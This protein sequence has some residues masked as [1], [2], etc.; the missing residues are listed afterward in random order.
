M[1]WSIRSVGDLLVIP[2][3]A[4][5]T[6]TLS[7]NYNWCLCAR[8]WCSGEDGRAHLA[9]RRETYEELLGR[10]QLWARTQPNQSVVPTGWA[11]SVIGIGETTSGPVHTPAA[12]VP[13]VLLSGLADLLTEA[14]ADPFTPTSW[15]FLHQASNASSRRAWR[16]S[17]RPRA[18]ATGVRERQFPVAVGDREPCRR[19]SQWRR[20]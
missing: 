2:A 16:C 10:D 4:L 5:H 12:S 9:V 7:N 15:R 13:D 14:P 1:R 8:R 17:V 20:N 11:W 19:S 6:F 18:T 3:T